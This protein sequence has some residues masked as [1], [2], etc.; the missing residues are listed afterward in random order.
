MAAG[1]GRRGIEE[2]EIA[3]PPRTIHSTRS[4]PM[5]SSVTPCSTWSRVFIS[6][7]RTPCGRNREKFDRA[8]RAIARRFAQA[9]RRG[10]EVRRTLF[11]QQRGGRFFHHLL[12][13][14]LERAVAF[15]K[16]DDAALAIAEDLH[17]DMARA[18]HVAFEEDAGIAEIALP[19]RATVA[20][21]SRTASRPRTRACRCRRRQRWP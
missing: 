8:G 4:M 17:F 19:R 18:A 12:V 5:T 16:R 9:D 14:A 21:P 13:A 10:V 2:R 6:R 20:K 15:A 3:R 7:K 1:R 11:G